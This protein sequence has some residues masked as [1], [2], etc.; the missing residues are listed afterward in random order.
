M[1][2]SGFNNCLFKTLGLEK[3]LEFFNQCKLTYKIDQSQSAFT[4][5]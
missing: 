4:I 2:L 5:L 1:N 3:Q